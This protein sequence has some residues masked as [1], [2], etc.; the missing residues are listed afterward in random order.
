VEA[1]PL[2]GP[3]LRPP[4]G[5]VLPVLLPSQWRQVEKGPAAAQRLDTPPRGE[6][7]AEDLVAVA[8]EDIEPEARGDVEVGLEAAGGEENQG[9]VQP[10]RFL[11]ASISADGARDTTAS[12]VSR[13]YRWARWTML[14]TTIEQPEQGSAS[15]GCSMWW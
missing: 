12:D 9:T 8:E 5:R 11:N 7:A 10:M 2:V 6:V 15:P 1:P 4:L 13:A 3:R 14:S